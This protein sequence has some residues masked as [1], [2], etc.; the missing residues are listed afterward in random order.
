MPDNYNNERRTKTRQGVRLVKRGSRLMWDRPQRFRRRPDR[1]LF[2]CSLQVR[3]VV[4][5]AT[6]L[7]MA[8]A[9]RGYPPVFAQQV[10]LDVTNSSVSEGFFEYQG[11]SWTLMGPSGFARFGQSHTQVSPFP[12]FESPPP[13]L[14]VHYGSRGWQGEFFGYWSSGIQRSHRSLTLSQTLSDGIYGSFACQSLR[15]FVIGFHPVF[16]SAPYAPFAEPPALA[17]QHLPNPGPPMPNPRPAVAKDTQRAAARAPAGRENDLP[18]EKL[19]GSA[20]SEDEPPLVLGGRPGPAE[21]ADS[22][23]GDRIGSL[24]QSSA[25]RVVMSVDEARALRSAEQQRDNQEAQRYCDLAEAAMKRGEQGQA[26]IYLR[27]AEKLASGDLRRKVLLLQQN[28][29]EAEE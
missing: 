5:S 23:K 14:G 22:A 12:V 8:L 11:T 21:A 1:H 19:E 25:E 9:S 26:R 4:L 18:V 13:A 10:R 29:G 3:A 27:M 20:R 6:A 16:A 28:L 7:V 15:P 2:A 17:Y 24:S